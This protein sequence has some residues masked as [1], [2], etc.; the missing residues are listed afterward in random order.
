MTPRCVR[1]GGRAK[2]D[3]HLTGRDDHGE[4]LD[5]E[6]AVSLCRSCHIAEGNAL[7]VL[8]LERVVGPLSRPERVE[9]RLRRAAVF[10]GRLA[11]KWGLLCGLAAAALTRWADELAEHTQRLDRRDPKWRETDDAA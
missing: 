10:L 2:D 11:A 7:R 8:D 4:Y 1:C 5:P 9:L 6:L 3:H